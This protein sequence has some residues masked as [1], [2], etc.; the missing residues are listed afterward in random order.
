LNS[1]VRLDWE[2]K[3]HSSERMLFP[4]SCGWYIA[5]RKQE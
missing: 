4:S 5:H 2:G 1:L 3:S